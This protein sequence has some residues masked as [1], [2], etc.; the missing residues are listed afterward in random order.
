M[1]HVCR[2]GRGAGFEIFC[3]GVLRGPE[4]E[5]EHLIRVHTTLVRLTEAE[6]M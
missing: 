5:S 3:A 6:T 4:I 2:A 1:I